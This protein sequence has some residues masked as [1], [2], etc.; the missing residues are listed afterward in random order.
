MHPWVLDNED[1]LVDGCE[2][3][4]NN[5]EVSF[6]VH[7]MLLIAEGEAGAE[8]VHGCKQPSSA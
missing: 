7:R 4:S 3:C 5:L 8:G 6:L 1:S 2:R